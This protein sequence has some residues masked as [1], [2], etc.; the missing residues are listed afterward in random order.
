MISLPSLS[1]P[2]TGIDHVEEKKK[3]TPSGDFQ[4]TLSQTTNFRLPN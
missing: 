1:V 2:L 4:L 3:R